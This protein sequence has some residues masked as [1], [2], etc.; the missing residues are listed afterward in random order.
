M[1][2]CLPF[3]TKMQS[4]ARRAYAVTHQVQCCYPVSEARTLNVPRKQFCCRG[5][6]AAH[7]LMDRAM[8][9]QDLYTAHRYRNRRLQ[10]LIKLT[11]RST[12]VYMEQFTWRFVL[13]VQKLCALMD[14]SLLVNGNSTSNV[15]GGYCRGS[16]TSLPYVAPSRL[17]TRTS[18]HS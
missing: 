14:A 13:F 8:H 17:E 9:L 10:S 6:L 18:Q 7:S 12:A 2:D 4:M 16:P 1:V 11:F 15:Q 5:C 3:A